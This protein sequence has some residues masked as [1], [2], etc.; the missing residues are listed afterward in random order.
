MVYSGVQK[1]GAKIG[2]E[3]FTYGPTVVLIS[4]ARGAR[5]ARRGTER[6]HRGQT[7]AANEPKQDPGRP[8]V[9]LK[10]GGQH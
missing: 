9:G 10:K 4:V 2:T 8:R 1:I 6:R 7:R 3:F 5:E